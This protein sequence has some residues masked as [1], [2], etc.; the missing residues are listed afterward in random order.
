MNAGTSHRSQSQSRRLQPLSTIRASRTMGS[1]ASTTASGRLDRRSM[2]ISGSPE[3]NLEEKILALPSLPNRMA[4][5][6]KTHRPSTVTGAGQL[7]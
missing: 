2:G 5:L 6:S 1:T 4:R 3:R 7:V